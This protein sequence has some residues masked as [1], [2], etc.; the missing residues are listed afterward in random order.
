MVSIH[1]LCVNN[2]AIACPKFEPNEALQDRVGRALT[3]GVVI[4]DANE[5]ELEEV[6]E[7]YADSA[8][9]DS[10]DQLKWVEVVPRHQP[11]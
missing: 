10:P 4:Y 5:A 9:L 8:D 1:I 7:A 2:T 3:T 6:K 11:V